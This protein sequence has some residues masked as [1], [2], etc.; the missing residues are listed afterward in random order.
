M[1][2]TVRLD[3]D[4]ERRFAEVCSEQRSS[5]SEVVTRLIEQYV[6]ARRATK[7]T[8]AELARKHKLIGSFI[9]PPDLAENAGRY[10]REKLGAD[11]SG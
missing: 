2:L 7:L 8:P 5:R 1:T 9:G 11:N 6:A 3:P 4:L 10:L